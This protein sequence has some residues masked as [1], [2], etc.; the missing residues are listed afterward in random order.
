MLIDSGS[1]YDADGNQQD[2]GALSYNATD[3]TSSFDATSASYASNNQTERTQLGDI[4]YVNGMLGL[5]SMTNADGTGYIERDPAG[6][7]ISYIRPG[8]GQ[9][10]YY[11]FDGSGNVLGLSNPTGSGLAATYAYDPFGNLAAPVGGGN[12]TVKNDQPLRF[13]AGIFDSTSG[14]YKFGQRYYQPTLGRWTQQ[15]SVEHLGSLSQGN[16]YGFVGDN[17]V[18]QMDPLGTSLLGDI[19][20]ALGVASDVASLAAPFVPGADL[21]AV[22][23]ADTSAALVCADGSDDCG[24]A[25]ANAAVSTATLGFAPLVPGSTELTQGLNLGLD[26]GGAI[27]GGY[28]LYSQF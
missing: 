24:S 20:D 22:G 3:Q 10:F 16:R 15:D 11:Y 5:Q 23:L 14:L 1:S 12:T 9:Q 4:S 18:N 17:P 2:P 27:Y 25:A 19:G 26:F 21:V 7:P 28:D 8:T 13:Q 6:T